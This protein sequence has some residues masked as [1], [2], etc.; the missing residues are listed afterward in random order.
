MSTR[1]DLTSKANP[2]VL[3]L[4]LTMVHS[5]QQGV[6]VIITEK[7]PEI[8]LVKFR[9][10]GRI[11]KNSGKFNVHLVYPVDGYPHLSAREE[12]RLTQALNTAAII[13]SP[14]MPISAVRKHMIQSDDAQDLPRRRVRFALG[15][16]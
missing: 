13:Q 1:N 9:L 11:S 7:L 15:A 4:T 8:Y 5:P 12:G 3:F 2:D 10:M 14:E 16:V 6:Q